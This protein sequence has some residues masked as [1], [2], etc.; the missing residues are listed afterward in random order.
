[1][2]IN[3]AQAAEGIVSCSGGDCGT[4]SLLETVNN[5]YNFIL[6]TG[7]AVAVLVL[8]LA[9][10][11]YILSGGNARL[12]N[13]AKRFSRAGILGFI[14]LLTGWLIVH[15]LV[16]AT[17][18]KSS[19]LWWNFEC[20]DGS[21][22]G[23]AAGMPDNSFGDR[24]HFGDVESFL[25]SKELSG[26]I[27]GNQ[28]FQTI[29]KQLYSLEEGQSLEFLAPQ[30]LGQSGDGEKTLNSL[31]T[32]KKQGGEVDLESVG[33]Y[34]NVLAGNSSLLGEAQNSGLS[35][36]QL[37]LLQKYFGNEKSEKSLVGADG[38]I[39]EA[40]NAGQLAALYS[41]LTQVLKGINNEGELADNADLF[42]KSP[43]ELLALA[44]E[45]SKQNNGQSQEDRLIATL[46]A[47]TIKMA[48]VVGVEKHSAEDYKENSNANENTNGNENSNENENDNGAID[49]EANCVSSGG[50][51]LTESGL[52]E[53]IKRCG[54][55]SA[56]DNSGE[57]DPSKGY[58][59]CPEAKCFDEEGLCVKEGLDSDGDGILNE[60]DRCLKTPPAE[61]AAINKNR[62]ANYGCSCFDLGNKK[63]QCP[64]S[65]CEG[66]YMLFYP[67]DN[68]VCKNGAY[69]A[70]S[71]GVIR[72]EENEQCRQENPANQNKN[73][74]SSGSGSG[75]GSG[76][77][78]DK[79]QD[80]FSKNKDD[81]SLPPGSGS[82]GH[83]TE[84]GD[85]S[86]EAIKKA[87]KRI[88][89]KDPLRYEM[90]MR[91]TNKIE[92][93]SFP[94]GLCYG[95]GYF[96]VNASLPIGV[97]DQVIMHEATHS[98][99]ACVDGG[100]G[101]ISKTERVAVA[102]ECGSLCREENPD[103]SEF[104]KQ[105]EGVTYKGKEV[106]GY[107]ARYQ[108]KVAPQGNL[109]TNAFR[110]NIAYA[111]SYGDRTEGPYKYGD[112]ESKIIIGMKENEEDIIK[113][114]VTSKRNCLSKPTSDLPK[115]SACE[116]ASKEIIIR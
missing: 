3:L 81:K 96:Q 74:N 102:N 9:G 114:A 69:Q 88:E 113:R 50:S 54:G 97:L 40:G 2:L 107:A 77:G 104:P 87:L 32:V 42:E 109:G 8:V 21:G 5:L 55:Q 36:E 34:F 58:C 23:S 29:L 31:L 76:K 57:E 18:F 41:A 26:K 17:G 6:G 14:L 73:D 85:G 112:C 15:S 79:I 49:K 98:A 37:S 46:L 116:N 13:Q 35:S 93:T 72:R 28:D 39:I 30:I 20:N 63:K 84:R 44:M 56:N 86:P 103:M 60:E 10:S 83:D 80:D 100:W 64:Q 12:F 108:T 16:L 61:K 62:G 94:G 25:K 92:R 48:G 59:R 7:F 110:S 24:V 1:M 111:F 47:E 52:G 70:Y 65:K 19:F 71:C 68:Q 22:F 99:H 43:A 45:Y 38:K 53:T 11:E 27:E 106:R 66:D 78:P 95:C 101:S 67:E 75:G 4:C 90:I 82:A 105:K 91:F 89:E 51:W 33:D 115:V